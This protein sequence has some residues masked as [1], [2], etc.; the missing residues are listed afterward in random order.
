M[1]FQ[2]EYISK[3]TGIDNSDKVFIDKAP[4]N[5][6]YIGFIKNVFPN[7]KIINCNRSA[8]D[9]CWSNFK[10][11]FSGNLK[12]ANDLTD[13]AQFYNMYIDLIKYKKNFFENDIYNLK[14][15]SLIENPKDEIKNILKF[16]QL[17]WDENCL[18]HENNSKLISTASFAQARKPI[19]KSAIN[20]SEKYKVYL[21]ELIINLKD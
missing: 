4:L 17:D 20:S 21:Q 3:I 16:C 15:N 14:Y 2:D 1:E 8:V 7:S 5:F 6:K 12:F 9:I 11:F 19:Y 10:N 13:L 18:N